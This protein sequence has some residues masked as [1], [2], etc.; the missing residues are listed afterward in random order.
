MAFCEGEVASTIIPNVTRFLHDRESFPNVDWI[1][2][3]AP[4]PVMEKGQTNYMSGVP[5]F[6]HAGI[7]PYTDEKDMPAAWAFLKWYATYGSKYLVVA[8]HQSTWRGT[9]QGELLP[10]SYGA[11][12]EAAKWVD[13]ES[14]DRVVG[15]VDLP[16]YR[17]TTLT[18]YSDVLQALSDPIMQCIN[19]EIT[20]EKCLKQAWQEA[21]KAL[22]ESRRPAS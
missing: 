7:S 9:E 16:G 11:V 3:F 19:G 6:S 15:R 22:E 5:N 13:V 21:E 17:E 1:T 12:D 4:F 20:P 2:G 10:L 18:A 8:G 14:Y